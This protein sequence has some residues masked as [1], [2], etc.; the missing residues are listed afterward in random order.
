MAWSRLGL[1]KTNENE[2]EDGEKGREK[3]REKSEVNYVSRKIYEYE[4]QY[5]NSKRMNLGV[6]VRRTTLKKE[7]PEN[8]KNTTYLSYCL[9]AHAGGIS[10]ITYG[11]TI[12]LFPFLIYS[13]RTDYI[14]APEL[15]LPTS[16]L[17]SLQIFPSL[18]FPSLLARP[19][20]SFT[21]ERL[22]PQR[23]FFSRF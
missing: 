18:F 4:H 10:H 19:F 21:S 1:T 12:L 5:I 15:P 7:S 8:V 13:N 22:C 2:N 14:V 9:L 6:G 17:S 16:N 20:P 11:P 23:P 3:R